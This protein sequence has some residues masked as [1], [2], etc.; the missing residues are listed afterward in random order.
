MKQYI[1]LCKD[2][3]KGRGDY[4][5]VHMTKLYVNGDASQARETANVKT[6]KT[7]TKGQSNYCSK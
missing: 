3:T 4:Y 5:F 2:N 1:Y 6:L 7:N